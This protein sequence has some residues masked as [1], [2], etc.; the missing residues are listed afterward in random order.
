MSVNMKVFKTPIIP[1]SQVDWLICCFNVEGV[2]RD[3]TARLLVIHFR[4]IT[5]ISML[6]L[7]GGVP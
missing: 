5:S 7:K 1:G 4:V 2:V 6:M 3:W